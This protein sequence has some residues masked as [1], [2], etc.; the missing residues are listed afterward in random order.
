MFIYDSVAVDNVLTIEE[1]VWMQADTQFFQEEIDLYDKSALEKKLNNLLN[2][3]IQSVEDLEQWLLKESALMEEIQEILSGVYIAFNRYNDDENIKKRYEYHQQDIMPML[4]TYSHKLNKK[5]YDNEFRK[6]LDQDKYGLLIRSRVNA[7]E[8]YR[9]ENIPLEIK[10]DHLH[11]EYFEITGSLTI[12]WEGEEKTIPQMKTYLMSK[13]RHVREKAWKKVWQ[14][15]QVHEERLNDIMTELITLRHQIAQNAGF[16]N[17]RDYMF[18][19]YERFDYTPEECFRFHEAVEEAVV[20]MVTE[21]QKKHHKQIGV[22]RYRPWDTQAIPAGQEPL[23]PFETTEELVEGTIDVFNQLDPDF[24]QLIAEMRDRDLLDLESRK[25]KSPGGFCSDLPVTGLP[26]IF[27]NAVGTQGDLSTMVHEGGHSV[28]HLL[29]TRQQTLADYKDVPMESAELASMS[30]ELFTL[31][32]WDRFYEDENELKRA[33]KEH[34][35]DIISFFP[36]AMVVDRFQHWMYENP[37]HTVEERE[38][39]FM[40]LVKR[41]NYAY[42][43]IEG[44]EEQIKARWL[45]QL[46][47]FEVPFYYIEYAIAQLGALQMWEQYHHDPQQ[48]IS[49]YK[50]ALALGSSKTLPEVYETAGIKFDFSTSKIKELMDFAQQRLR[51][52]E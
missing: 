47:I 52:L 43:D 9:E 10:E 30:M 35:E 16:D 37:N 44:V 2:E 18:K 24:G 33:Q 15:V 27:M 32:K 22:E 21:I 26:F 17:Y 51:E 4:K 46:H 48:A 42:L 39:K 40:D 41:Y 6:Q 38:E 31:D 7:I 28:H 50:K 49:N 14:E 5:F 13:E 11:N 20:P 1:M 29:S 3:E 36:W 45:L 8:L 19:K 25:A 12:D 23:K 34:I